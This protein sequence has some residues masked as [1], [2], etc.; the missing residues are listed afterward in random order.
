MFKKKKTITCAC[1][2]NKKK[3]IL[4]NIVL[5]FEKISKRGIKNLGINFHFTTNRIKNYQDNN[6]AFI[7]LLT[8]MGI[9]FYF[10]SYA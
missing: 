5:F 6:N 3:T 9:F 1:F 2:F 10:D 8:Q 7:L 4:V